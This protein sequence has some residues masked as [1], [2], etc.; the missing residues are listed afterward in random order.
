MFYQL[1]HLITE[2]LLIN[3]DRDTPLHGHRFDVFITTFHC[4]ATAI[5]SLDSACDSKRL[6]C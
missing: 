5:L 2:L 6:L 4:T 3:C 1:H